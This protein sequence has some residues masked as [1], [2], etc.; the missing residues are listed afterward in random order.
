MWHRRADQRA[1][2]PAGGA[3][4]VHRVRV[5]VNRPL[6]AGQERLVLV[7]KVIIQEVIIDVIAGQSG[8]EVVVI[9]QRNVDAAACIQAKG[10]IKIANNGG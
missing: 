9:G 2:T 6:P 10:V 4:P 3:D 1:G 7:F 8:I 5:P